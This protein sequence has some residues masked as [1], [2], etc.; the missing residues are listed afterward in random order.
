[1]WGARGRGPALN[2]PLATLNWYKRQ[3]IT[4]ASVMSRVV[5]TELSLMVKPLLGYQLDPGSITRVN[6]GAD[7]IRYLH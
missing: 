1:M 7:I 2:P 3:S 6:P 5:N 4:M